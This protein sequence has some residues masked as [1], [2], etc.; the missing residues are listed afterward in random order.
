MSHGALP[1]SPVFALAGRRT[2]APGADVRRFPVEEAAGVRSRLRGEMAAHHARA[3]VCSAAAGADLLALEA[4]GELGLRR[5]VVLP[6]GRERFRETSVVDRPGDFGPVYDRV[7]DAVEAAGDLVVLE[8]APT[9]EAAYAAANGAILDEAAALAAPDPPV[10]VMVWDGRS[11]GAGDSTVAFAEAA[12]AR[13]V[14]VLE[15]LTLDPSGR[16]PAG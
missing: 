14:T 1:R 11:R 9:D 15:V 3:L 10:A 8:G 5:R 16:A 6:F 2:D 4:A 7:L 12:R 13:G